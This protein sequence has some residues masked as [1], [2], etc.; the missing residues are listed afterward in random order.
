[1]LK[2]I[3][4]YTVKA[5]PGGIPKLLETLKE[6]VQT[7]LLTHDGKSTDL[8]MLGTIHRL[9]KSINDPFFSVTGMLPSSLKTICDFHTIN[10]LFDLANKIEA[11]SKDQHMLFSVS[12]RLDVE[13]SRFRTAT[14][15]TES[16]GQSP[17]EMAGV[18]SLPVSRREKAA[19]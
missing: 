6:T 3:K 15:R 17:A 1:M 13:Y 18:S 19:H 5:V 11:A 10:F 12:S 14:G 9:I 7:L 8:K 16:A 4:Q 2:L